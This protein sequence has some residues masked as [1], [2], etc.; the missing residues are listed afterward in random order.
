MNDTEMKNNSQ[1]LAKQIDMAQYLSYHDTPL[2]EVV[3][4]GNLG[5][6]H[7]FYIHAGVLIRGSDFFKSALQPYFTS[8][9]QKR[10]CLPDVGVEEFGTFARWVYDRGDQIYGDYLHY[11]KAY[12]LADRLLASTFKSDILE[13]FENDIQDDLSQ[14]SSSSIPYRDEFGEEIMLPLPM[15]EVIELAAIVYG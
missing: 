8:G 15:N 4:G 3:V 12:V 7:T 14:L 13:A 2:V 1:E 6:E 5:P 9:E 11:A 10:V